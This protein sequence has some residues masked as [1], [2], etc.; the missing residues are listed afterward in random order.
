MFFKYSFLHNVSLDGQTH[1][2]QAPSDHK[3]KCT[4]LQFSAEEVGFWVVF[5]ILGC[6]KQR[7]LILAY[8]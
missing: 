1:K 8:A 4:Q 6:I 7:M 5:C 3:N 2:L